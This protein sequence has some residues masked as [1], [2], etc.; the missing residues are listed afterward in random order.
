MR[1]PRS[2]DP[3]VLDAN[4]LADWL[5]FATSQRPSTRAQAAQRVYDTCCVVVYGTSLR[6]EAVGAAHHRGVRLRRTAVLEWIRRKESEGKLHRV[7]ESRLAAA[8]LDA[9]L[10]RRLPA[11]DVHVV[12]LAVVSRAVLVVSDDTDFVATACE[13][14]RA[15]GI[16]IDIVSPATLLDRLG[17]RP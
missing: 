11:E 1:T 6:K 12:K 3:V 17:A 10:G 9:E 2:K 4:V 13:V 16:D 8:E 5:L 15:C 14:R 7:R